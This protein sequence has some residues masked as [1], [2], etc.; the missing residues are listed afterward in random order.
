MKPV[1]IRRQRKHEA[2]QAIKDLEERGFV[3]VYPLTEIAGEGKLFDR[4]SYN[5]RIFVENTH[6]SCWVAKMSRVSDKES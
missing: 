2:E 4:D 6:H 1:V 5:R 3:V